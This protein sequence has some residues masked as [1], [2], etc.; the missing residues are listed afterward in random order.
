MHLKFF[1]DSFDVVKQA[2]LRSLSTLGPW[3]T[4]PMF[5]EQVSGP[6]ARDF[7]DL[8]DQS[9]ARG[10]EREQ[11]QEKLAALAL[12]HIHGWAY[13]SHACFLLTGSSRAAVEESAH[14]IQKQLRLP[15]SRFV[16]EGAAGNSGDTIHNC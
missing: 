1:G 5:T 9:V 6:E 16:H 14:A 8:F 3:A 12:H 11:L 10:R 4:H 13:V 2:M 15:T 7:A